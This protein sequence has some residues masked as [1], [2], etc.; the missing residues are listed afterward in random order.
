MIDSSEEAIR[1]KCWRVY[2]TAMFLLKWSNASSKRYRIKHRPNLD[3]VGI[4][5]DH[6]G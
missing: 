6:S 4:G 5:L 2:E 1:E 3:R